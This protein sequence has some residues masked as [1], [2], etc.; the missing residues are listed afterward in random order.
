MTQGLYLNLGCG[1]ITLPGE[2]PPH[3]VVVEDALYQYPLWTNVDWNAGPGVDQVWDVFR[4]PW[5]LP[6]N[7]YDGAFLGHILE[8]CPHKPE[9]NDKPPKEFQIE[10]HPEPL[11]GKFVPNF[12]YNT[13]NDWWRQ[14]SEELAGLQ[15]GYYAFLAELHRVLRPGAIVHILSPYGWSQGAITDPTHHRLMTEQLFTHNSDDSPFHYRDAGAK[16]E[17]DAMNFQFT[18]YFAHLAITPCDG[19]EVRAYK[20]REFR[21]AIATQ[22]NVADNI[23][24]KLRAVKDDGENHI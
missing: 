19:L 7:A 5:P 11:D 23:Y 1:S 12:A 21:K 3:H 6:S 16:F 15:D 17:V 18:A 10:I 13:P 22:L 14:R 24:V 4:Y 20:E 8:H 9:T 2:K